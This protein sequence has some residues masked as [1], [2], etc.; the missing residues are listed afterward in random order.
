[1]Q[2]NLLSP[3]GFNLKIAIT[4]N[5]NYS[6][7]KVTMPGLQLGA[8]NIPTPFVRLSNPGNLTYDTLDVTFKVGENLEN[9]LEIFNWMVALGHPDTFTQYE[10]KTSDASVIIL[11][12][13]R[14]PI[15]SV[16]F[17]DLY[18]ASLSPID[19]NT[20]LTDIQYVDAVVQFNF[21]RFY[22]DV[23]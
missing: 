11:N 8:A 12:S 22:Y 16:H 10:K 20:T 21:N 9:Y 5:V 17:T 1:M 3:L 6:V 2:N 14:H 4:P 18:P 15:F 7:Q 19:F 13:A 23:L